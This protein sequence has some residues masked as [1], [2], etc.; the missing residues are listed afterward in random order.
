MDSDVLVKGVQWFVLMVFLLGLVVGG[1]LFGGL[2]L[3]TKYF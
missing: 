3:A 1:V 2:Y